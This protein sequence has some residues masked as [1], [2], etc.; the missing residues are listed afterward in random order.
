MIQVKSDDSL[1]RNHQPGAE[2]KMGKG[3]VAWWC[4]AG[5][6]GEIMEEGF[7]RKGRE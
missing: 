2:T 5:S 6:K 7:C 4:A 1:G 3:K